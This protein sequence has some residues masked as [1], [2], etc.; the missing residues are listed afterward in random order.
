MPCPACQSDDVLP[1]FEQRQMPVY[2]NVLWPTKEEA[3]GAARGDIELCFCSSCTMIYNRAFDPALVSYTPDYENSL[4][5]SPRFAAYAD[6]LATRLVERLDLRDSDI[7]EIGC[8]KGEFLALLCEKGNNRG[9]GFDRSYAGDVEDESRFTVV[10]DDYGEQHAHHDADL[11]CSR[12]V[13][14]HIPTPRPFLSL[15]KKAATQREGAA[16]FFE[17]PNA[18]YTLE[19]LGIWDIIYEHCLYFTPTA[20]SRLFEAT[21]LSV[22]DVYTAFDNQFLCVEAKAHGRSSEDQAWRARLKEADALRSLVQAFRTHHDEKVATWT[23]LLDELAGAGKRAV[24]W[25]A[26]SKGVTFL[27]AIPSSKRAVTRVV[28]INPRKHGRF[29]AGT[30]HEV[31]GPNALEAGTVDA[32]LI[33]NGIYRSEIEAS[34]AE[35]GV[36]ADIHV[37]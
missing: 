7:V 20:L 11:F 16:L 26:G 31:V 27:N 19:D 5:F 21:G 23:K 34:L 2:C 6:E 22:R 18:L 37:V 13:L 29:V 12:H 24:V 35:L 32:V 4:H 30:G 36:E 15:V 3:E 33:M 25:G 10:R 14:E 1:F 8:G 28:D 9:L 17:V